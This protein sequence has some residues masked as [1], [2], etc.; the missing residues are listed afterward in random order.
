MTVGNGL[1]P[2]ACTFLGGRLYW[3]QMGLGVFGLLLAPA[4]LQDADPDHNEYDEKKHGDS[5]TNSSPV[6][7][8]DLLL[9]GCLC[10]LLPSLHHAGRCLCVSEGNC[11]SEL[12]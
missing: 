12:A 10:S 4:L 6:S 9:R 7:R 3:R 5:R 1:K 2:S 11:G 8:L